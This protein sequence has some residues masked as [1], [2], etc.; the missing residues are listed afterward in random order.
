MISSGVLVILVHLLTS[1]G[2]SQN[3]VGEP[4][5]SHIHLSLSLCDASPVFGQTLDVSLTGISLVVMTFRTLKRYP[6]LA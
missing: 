2:E 5:S 6:Q 3:A 4:G 1:E